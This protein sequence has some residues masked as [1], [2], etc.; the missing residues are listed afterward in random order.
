MVGCGLAR[1]SLK[2]GAK[3]PE[4]AKL[5]CENSGVDVELLLDK[6]NVDLSLVAQCLLSRLSSPTEHAKDVRQRWR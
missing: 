5:L 2:E 6:F 3:K 1:V 4:L